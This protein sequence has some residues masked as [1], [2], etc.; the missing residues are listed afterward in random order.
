MTQSVI[1]MAE[2]VEEFIKAMKWAPDTSAEVRGLVEA[3]VRGFW[4]YIHSEKLEGCQVAAEIAYKS[5]WHVPAIVR[6][7][8]V[9]IC[10]DEFTEDQSV[11]LNWGPEQI[12]A[13]R[14]DDGTVFELTS[15]ETDFWSCEAGK[16]H[17]PHH[18]DY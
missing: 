17:N 5:A 4:A 10:A 3:N 16:N 13:I 14:R 6:E 12:T 2:C 11:G 18:D 8:P 1:E 15:E 9:Y 7:V